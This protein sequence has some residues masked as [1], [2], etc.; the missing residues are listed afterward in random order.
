MK[1]FIIVLAVI[2]SSG[3][4][5]ANS[6]QR[7][8]SLNEAQ[9]YE[10]ASEV[11][12]G[13]LNNARYRK[14][15][16]EVA[17][18]LAKAYAGLGLK[19]AAVFN[20]IRAVKTAP[21]KRLAKYLEVLSRLAFDVGDTAGLNYALSKINISTFPKSQKPIL[22]FRFG[23]A[24]LRVGRLDKAIKAF[25][26]VPSGHQLSTKA[27]YFLGLAHAENGDLRSAYSA[28]TRA[29][30]TRAEKGVA[31]NQRVASLMGRA[32]V[33]Y[34]MKRWEESIAAYRMIPRDS[35]YFH[36]ML[37]ESAWAMLRAGKFRSAL[38]NF[39]SLHSEYYDSYFFPEATLLRGIIYLYI[40]KVD[41]VN[42]VVKVYE[43]TYGKI[44][45]DLV[46][47]LKSNR[48]PAS[49]VKNYRNFFNDFRS[50]VKS[51]Q[52]AYQI[53]YVLLRHL[54]RSSKVK[55]RSDY[56]YNLESELSKIASLEAWSETRAA[57]YAKT[58]IN[59][60]L[61]GSLKRLG[62]ALRQELI[63]YKKDLD[64]FED[65]KE[66]VKFELISAEKEDARKRLEGRDDFD[67]E[68][69]AK[70]S[71]FTYTKNGYEYWPFQGEYWLD[72]IGN[73]HYLGVSR[74]E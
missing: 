57:R 66:L 39:Q 54:T 51:E 30:N 74:C 63:S 46:S 20:L 72:E 25:S 44:R 48:S 16:S 18:E 58:I 34:Q 29:A 45:T 59:K 15:Q 8:K 7:G 6:L 1:S 27:S 50:G 38:S 33:L 32:R 69:K 19:Q 9:N 2:F 5:W 24:Y 49:D 28:F 21:K 61:R 71:R 40:C 62:V 55:M 52:G 14:S 31:D 42:K 11:L 22:Y 41:E 67:A 23:Q 56:Y 65:Q 17:Y 36:E 35:K 43:K 60:R 73:Y 47:Y 37:F 26:K 13:V 64:E 3:S 70:T 4:L 68:V 53:P 10:A 12:Y